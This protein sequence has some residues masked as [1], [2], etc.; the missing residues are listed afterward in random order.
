MKNLTIIWL[1]LALV[2]SGCQEKPKK[3]K[4]SE[5]ER[6]GGAKMVIEKNINKM[7][8]EKWNKNTYLEIKEK[9][10]PLLELASEKEAMG[11]LLNNLY[12]KQMVRDANKIMDGT[13]SK[14]H[15][16]LDNLFKELNQ[17]PKAVG[18]DELKKRKKKHDE[19]QAFVYSLSKKQ[20]VS[21]F[22]DRYDS[23][24]EGQKRR[25]ASHLLV[26]AKPTCESIKKG[27]ENPE[28]FF[29]RRQKQ[30]CDDLVA[31]Y[32]QKTSFSKGDQ[33]IV[34][35]RLQFYK[36]DKSVWEKQIEEFEQKFNTEN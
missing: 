30:F 36:G 33:N 23:S 22:R 11:A 31:L 21:S 20:I 13:C 8:D 7:F 34:L 15:S 17:F 29:A 18:L 5:G 4:S 12:G 3:R 10:L 28:P 14:E 9:Q 19:L 25:E 27:L 24:F 6:L 35:G 1:L 2:M 16:L 26:T 32:L